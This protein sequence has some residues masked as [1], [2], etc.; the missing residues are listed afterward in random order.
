MRSEPV[1]AVGSQPARC[2]QEHPHAPGSGGWVWRSLPDET[3]HKPDQTSHIV[4]ATGI[5]LDPQVVSY[6]IVRRSEDGTCH[7]QAFPDVD[8][9]GD[10]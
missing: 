3:T 7:Q 2:S 1:L 6:S 9:T 5:K 4:V 10:E 8:R